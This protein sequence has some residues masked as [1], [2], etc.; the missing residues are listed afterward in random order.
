MLLKVFPLLYYYI[1]A[2]A[3][4]CTL[5]FYFRTKNQK[6][7]T[8]VLYVIC[9]INF[10]FYIINDYYAYARGDSLLTMMPFQLCNIAV[11]LIPLSLLL[12]KELII[13]FIFYICAPGALIALLVPNVEYKGDPYSLMTVS[14]FIFHYSIVAVP[15]LSAGWNMYKPSPTV[16]KAIRLSITILTL[17]GLIHVLNLI[18]GAVF[19][20]EANYFFTIIKYSAP[21]NVAFKL[22]S[23]I[24]PYDFFY[25]LPGLIVLYVYMF[26]IHLIMLPGRRQSGK[27]GNP[28]SPTDQE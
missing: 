9:V 26:I 16:K 20:V 4:F 25:L 18:L 2:I 24:I 22:L 1:A 17:A 28:C 12:K 23:K 6:T 8:A 5:L 11:F 7:K 21:I 10:I 14:F 13:D 27:S 3:V 19:H 15:F